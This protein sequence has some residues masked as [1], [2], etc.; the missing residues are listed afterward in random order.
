MT[1]LWNNTLNKCFVYHP[2]KKSVVI[3]KNPVHSLTLK[4][5][6]LSPN[7]KSAMSVAVCCG[8]M[9]QEHDAL[10]ITHFGVFKDKECSF[11][12]CPLGSVPSAGES[13]VI[14]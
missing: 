9:E 11:F 5:D 1:A 3:Q 8:V 10:K 14:C 6:M 12:L 4:E 7:S 13:H 2:F